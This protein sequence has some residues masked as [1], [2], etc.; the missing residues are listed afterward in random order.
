MLTC[1]PWFREHDQWWYCTIRVN[2]RQRQRKLVRGR[3]NE[4]IA[5]DLYHQLMLD[6]GHDRPH[7]LTFPSLAGA[8]LKAHHDEFKPTTYDWYRYYLEEFC[9]HHPYEAISV[10]PS[11][12]Q[13]WTRSK[14][15]GDGSTRAAITCIKRVYNWAVEDGRLIRSPLA[16]LKRPSSGR[17]EVTVDKDV[18]RNL[19]AAADKRFKVVLKA[20][21]LTGVRPS[22]LCAVTRD[23]VDLDR[24]IWV[25]PQHKTVKKTKRPRIVYLCP[26]MVALTRTLLEQ[27]TE[28]EPHLFKNRFGKHLTANAIRCRFRNLRTKLGLAENVIAYAYR[29]TFATEALDSGMAPQHV[30]KLLGHQGLDMLMQYDHGDQKTD[31]LTQAAARA[32]DAVGE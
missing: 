28:E 31:S 20:L 9:N 1:T 24:G 3:E 22:E 8:F 12:V 14:G 30:A 29:H 26:E 25:L 17:R 4:Q 13:E 10:K 6:V 16:G 15:W 2:G 7:V 21:R 19:L 27:T 18:H 5:Q 11:E 23:M 32:G